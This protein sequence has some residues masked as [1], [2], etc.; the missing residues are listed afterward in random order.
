MKAK[1][2]GKLE[3]TFLGTILKTRIAV[4]ASNWVFQCM[5]YMNIYELSLKLLIDLVFV[6][7]IMSFFMEGIPFGLA[8]LISLVIAHT[9]N[10]IINGHIFVLMRYVA[11]VPKTEQH[12]EDFIVKMKSAAMTWDSIDG[13]AIY[14][15]YCRGSLHKFSDL[16]VRVLTHPGVMNAIYGALFCF[17]QRLIAFF[18]IFPLDIYCC[19]KMEFLDQLRDDENPFILIDH[20]GRLTARYKNAGD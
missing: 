10:W 18:D 17:Y 5:R 1:P 13:V 11:P 6:V 16:D 20:S 7:I 2:Q 4:I 19:D 9:I 12:F 8:L 15:S 14:G 3:G